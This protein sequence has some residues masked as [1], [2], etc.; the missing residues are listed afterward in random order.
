[1]NQ[2][3]LSLAGISKCYRIYTRP[4]DRFKQSLSDRLGHLWGVRE[5]PKYY[6]E[7]WALHDI[8][9]ELK[10]GEAVGI[11]GRNGAGKST[12]LQIIAGTLA[13][14]SGAVKTYGRTTALLELGS[15]FNPEF[16]GRENVLLNAQILGMSERGALEKFDSIA[17]FADIGDFIDQPVKTYSSGMM[18]RLAFSVQVELSPNLL[19][20][21]EAIAVGDV[22]FQEKCYRKLADLRDEGTALLFVSHDTN[23]VVNLCDRA[24]LLEGGRLIATGKPFSVVRKYMEVLYSDTQPKAGL[25]QEQASIALHGETET[26]QPEQSGSPIDGGNSMRFG[27]KKVE[28]VS[29]EIRDEEGQ[30]VDILVSGDPYLFIHTFIVRENVSNISSGLMIRNR[31]GIDLF[32]VTNKTLNTPLPALYKGQIYEVTFNLDMHLSAGDYFLQ[33]ANAGEDGV[34]FDCWIQALHFKVINTPSLFT[35]SVVNLNPKLRF[36]ERL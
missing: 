17:G 3:P 31:L 34:Q 14:T 19:I 4:E 21:D 26:Q 10:A 8:S 24:L 16:T 28:I 27:T 36:E 25:S 6:S 1:M 35:T 15:G 20:I 23:A 2:L 7:H 33:V 11:I 12:L 22:R 9:F 32:G 18:M 29:V 13:P 5:K 30:S